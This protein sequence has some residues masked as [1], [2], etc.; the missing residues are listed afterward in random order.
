[1][2]E[3][4]DDKNLYGLSKGSKPAPTEEQKRLKDE[5]KSMVAT[6]G[7]R[8]LRALLDEQGKQYLNAAR[9]ALDDPDIPANE[10]PTTVY[11]IICNFNANRSF[12]EAIDQLICEGS[13]EDELKN[14]HRAN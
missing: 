12:L 8:I 11:Q 5:M 6:N 4:K 1:M 3:N 14:F 13:T 10:R 9:Y 2:S 7:F